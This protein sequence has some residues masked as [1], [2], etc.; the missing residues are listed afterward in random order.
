MDRNGRV[1]GGY[2][3]LASSTMMMKIPIHSNR[4]FTCCPLIAEVVK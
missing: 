2:V 3:T 1:L 4:N